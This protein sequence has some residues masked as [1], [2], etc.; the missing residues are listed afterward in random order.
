MS[1]FRRLYPKLESGDMYIS[2]LN[3]DADFEGLL[4][5]GK[6]CKDMFSPLAIVKNE[7]G[8]KK[9]FLYSFSSRLIVSEKAKIF[10]ET[11][12]D[13][14]YLE[15]IPI[16]FHD[17]KMPK[18]YLLNILDLVDAFDLNKSIYRFFDELGPK[19]NK[20]LMDYE[21]VE[22]DIVKTENRKLF[23]ML[24]FEGNII[25]H[26]DFFNEIINSGLTGLFVDPLWG[27]QL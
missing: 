9:D 17:K 22:I 6:S 25:I 21:K 5:N 19:G 1:I 20:V 3:I 24:Y 27:H 4:F 23:S 18:Y 14:S 11:S 7:K 12:S 10:L 8:N 15:F 2:E 16:N 13:A 26:Q